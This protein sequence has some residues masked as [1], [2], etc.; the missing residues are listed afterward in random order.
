MVM[1]Y[2]MVANQE[3]DG[4]TIQLFQDVDPI[5]TLDGSDV[6]LG[7]SVTTTGGGAYDFTDLPAGNYIVDVTDTDNVLAGYVL[8]GGA[9][10]RFVSILSNTDYDD[11]DFGYQEQ[12]GS[13]GDFVWNDLNGNGVQ[14]G[15]G[16]VGIDNVAVQTLSGCYPNWDIRRQRCA[17]RPTCSDHRWRCL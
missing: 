11:A 13:I 6:P 2:K 3:F 7:V 12:T 9:D 4:V 5:G 15:G 1:G 16:E 10:P 14:D 17:S 8:T